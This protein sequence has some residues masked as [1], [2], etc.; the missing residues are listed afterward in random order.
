MKI[1]FSN[2]GEEESLK[3]TGRLSH[4][5]THTCSCGGHSTITQLL[6]EHGASVGI[7]N[8]FGMTVLHHAAEGGWKEDVIQ[9]IVDTRGE[10]RSSRY[11]G[12]DSV[13]YCSVVQESGRHSNILQ[14][15]S[16]H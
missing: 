14:I 13:T 4:G 1:G 9:I 2:D 3:N 6:L 12:E 11:A 10:Y 8:D 5:F 7:K 15:W 16:K